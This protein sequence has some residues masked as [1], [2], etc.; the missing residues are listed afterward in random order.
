MQ[1][2]LPSR[3]ARLLEPGPDPLRNGSVLL[4]ALIFCAGLVLLGW[5]LR[6]AWKGFDPSPS[7]LAYRMTA[8]LGALGGFVIYLRDLPASSARLGLIVGGIAALPWALVIV[9]ESIRR[10][11]GRAGSRRRGGRE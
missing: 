10:G 6:A 9:L 3:L 4:C 8:V 11:L 7:L 2:A 1:E 5:R